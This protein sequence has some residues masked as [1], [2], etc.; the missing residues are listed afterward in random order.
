MRWRKALVAHDGLLR[1]A[2][3]KHGGYVFKH[4]GDGCG[5]R[6]RLADVRGGCGGRCAAGAGSCQYGMGIATGE[7][8]LREGD[9][10]GAVR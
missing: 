10:F 7:A 4:T 3:E 6:V 1:T 2:I 9:Y 5:R 8:E